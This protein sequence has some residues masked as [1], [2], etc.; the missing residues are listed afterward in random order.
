MP[1]VKFT[2]SQSQQ[3]R[4]YEREVQK[5]TE[6]P[7]D[8]KSFQ[9][10]RFHRC[11]TLGFRNGIPVQKKPVLGI[12]GERLLQDLLIQGQGKARQKYEDM[13]EDPFKFNQKRIYGQSRPKSA[14]AFRPK[15]CDLDQKVLRFFAHFD[16]CVGDD[17][18]RRLVHILYYLVD[19]TMMI[20][21]PRTKNSGLYQGL[22]LKRHRVPLND[23]I[24]GEGSF[25]HWTDIKIGE[26]LKIYGRTYVVRSCDEF[27]RKYLTEEGMKDSDESKTTGEMMVSNFPL[28]MDIHQHETP[29][30]ANFQNKDNPKS[31]P[32]ENKLRKFYENDGRVLRFMCR[33][34]LPKYP[35]GKSGE[36][37]FILHFYLADDTVEIREM[38][39][40]RP[41][42]AAGAKYLRRQQVPKT[43]PRSGCD[44]FPSSIPY[45]P[46]DFY[47][48]KDFIVGENVSVLNRRFYIYDCDAFTKQY[49]QHVLGKEV[50]PQKTVT[51]PSPEPIIPVPEQT[52][53]TIGNPEDSL[54]NC[55]RLTPKPPKKDFKKFLEFSGKTL[56]FEAKIHS[57]WLH[58]ANR[59]FIFT[60]FLC[61]DTV[62][63][64]ERLPPN[65]GRFC[66]KYLE[67]SKVAKPDLKVNGETDFYSIDDFYIG[68]ILIIHGRKFEIVGA[69]DRVL[70]YLIDESA[71]K[72]LPVRNTSTLRQYF[73]DNGKLGPDSHDSNPAEDETHET[74][75]NQIRF[76]NYSLS[77]SGEEND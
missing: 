30:R 34:D 6:V 1:V 63:I 45:S 76:D 33:S 43:P 61:D 12:G 23:S 24:L 77:N 32:K 19:D 53:V 22:Q 2:R 69:D 70:K 47:Q 29:E 5:H 17:F 36:K 8:F 7:H 10:T 31:Y 14:P 37:E 35:L 60:Y 75:R 44:E 54:Q 18:R 58:D 49:I 52:I 41:Q 4:E 55:L 46:E 65:S 59:K 11:Q 67:R 71:R 51:L 68:S 38:R 9:P 56:R 25:Y 26:P 64:F 21:E 74:E 42:S 50:K 13:V 40:E 48:S 15:F 16:E 3:G 28:K 72:P 62:S 39:S 27:T 73:Q 57:P 20:I 66:G